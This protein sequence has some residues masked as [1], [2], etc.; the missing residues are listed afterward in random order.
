[1]DWIYVLNSNAMNLS[2]I[3]FII[4]Y[5]KVFHILG[6][7][8]KKKFEVCPPSNSFLRPPLVGGLIKDG[9]HEE[10]NVFTVPSNRYA[11]FNMF[12]DPLAAKTVVESNLN[13]TL[14]PLTA[15]Q[16]VASFGAVLDALEQTQQTPESKFVH[17]LFSLL[18]ELQSKQKL[19]HHV[20]IF[21]GEVL[22]AVYM[23][24]G[25]DL[26]SSVQLKTINVVAN[27][28]EST[29]GQIVISKQSTKLV[30][31]LSHFDGKTYYNRLANS[32]ANKKQSAVIGSFEEQ[33]AIWSRPPNN[34]G[35]GHTK[36]L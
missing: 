32:L 8:Q 36:F 10:G 18:K 34:S 27:T 25:S 20:D 23:V 2:C 1:M 33:M 9:G 6:G 3:L 15:Q 26:K 5:A 31:V 19:Y 29:D 28:T 13:I 17:G 12:L 24:Q 16:K 4:H 11:E 22:G 30:K 21:L 7:A 14:I 35:P